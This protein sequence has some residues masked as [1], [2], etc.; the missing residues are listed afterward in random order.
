M[1]K[2]I[3]YLLLLIALML[4]TGSAQAADMLPPLE[5]PPADVATAVENLL[6]TD[7][8]CPDCD[9]FV[10]TDVRRMGFTYTISVAGLADVE[11]VLEWSLLSDGEWLGVITVDD[12]LTATGD[13]Q[14]HD[15]VFYSVSENEYYYFPWLIGTQAVMGSRGVH[16]NGDY[17]L[18]GW[19]AIDWV[20]GPDYGD[21]AAPNAVYASQSA[22]ISYVCRDDVQVAIRAGDFLYA[23]LADNAYLEIGHQVVR[24]S[25]IG[26]LVTGTFSDNC[27]W[28]SQQPE[29]YHVH[30]MF[31]PTGQ[32]I[33]IENWVLDV[34]SGIW[35]NSQTGTTKTTGD[36]F[37]A[38]WAGETIAP[39][40]PHVPPDGPVGPIG[41]GE[42]IWDGLVG[43][44]NSIVES[45]LPIFP[46]PEG[47]Q[48][49]LTVISSAG[50]IIRVFYVLVS[51]HF[52]MGTTL[53]VF[54]VIM[55]LEPVRIG[56]SI[57]MLIK[58]LVPGM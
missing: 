7:N 47:Q 8:P 6:V 18:D 51:S 27:G 56:K 19:Y 32:H 54:G 24:G 3:I 30:W 11:N 53:L 13:W 33:G 35:T 58:N 29:N 42:S 4:P 49:G 1:A 46:N 37:I 2:P 31:H 16:G 50:A 22:E 43:V 15:I 26:S 12:S 14:D 55:I 48:I 38:E 39:G 28:A 57:Y 36:S 52:R 34:S 5:E 9:Y 10:I 41:T 20:S 17:G 23:H 25:P 40:D 44:L 21:S 45:V